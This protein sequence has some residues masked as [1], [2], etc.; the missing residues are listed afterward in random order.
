M[1]RRQ[2]EVKGD[3]G[4]PG[5]VDDKEN[6]DLGVKKPRLQKALARTTTDEADDNVPEEDTKTLVGDDKVEKANNDNNIGE[7]ANSDDGLGGALKKEEATEESDVVPGGLDKASEG[8]QIVREVEQPD[9]LVQLASNT[10]EDDEDEEGG[11]DDEAEEGGLDQPQPVEGG[12]EQPV[13][14]K[15]LDSNKDEDVEE[16]ARGKMTKMRRRRKMT[17]MRGV[18]STCPSLMRRRGRMTR[19][20]RRLT[21]LNKEG[22]ENEAD[23][24]L[25]DVEVGKDQPDME[26]KEV[27]DEDKDDDLVDVEELFE[28]IE[29]PDMNKSDI[30]KP[31][32]TEEEI[33]SEDNDNVLFQP[34][35]HEQSDGNEQPDVLEQADLNKKEIEN[36]EFEGENKEAVLDQPDEE[37][38]DVENDSA[39]TDHVGNPDEGDQDIQA[40]PSSS[41]AAEEKT[42]EYIEVSDSDDDKD[43]EDDHIED[44]SSQISPSTHIKVEAVAVKTEPAEA[45]PKPKP[46]KETKEQRALRH[47]ANSLHFIQINQFKTTKQE[48]EDDVE[49]LEVVGGKMKN[50]EVKVELIQEHYAKVI[51]SGKVTKDNIFAVVIA[52]PEPKEK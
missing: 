44:K 8:D 12:I 23:E 13:N 40:L 43:D 51:Q 6:R 33:E 30:K 9:N 32:T 17:R 37:L 46:P 14:I 18:V 41:S 28:P 48:P 19:M 49:E 36:E 3:D 29:Q 15:Q 21:A 47:K 2:I 35:S 45:G 22:V 10:D 4:E 31:D 20:R 27:E 24:G 34:D 39:A 25:V 50:E 42:F 16:V 52:K 11:E 7:D 26:Q 1:K 5:R 38:I